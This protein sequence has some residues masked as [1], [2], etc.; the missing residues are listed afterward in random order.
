M[1]KV[2]YSL[3][4]CHKTM[5]TQWICGQMDGLSPCWDVVR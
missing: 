1:M 5:Y 3:S 4:L 2:M